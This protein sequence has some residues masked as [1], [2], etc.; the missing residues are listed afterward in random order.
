MKK[1]LI[2]NALP[3]VLLFITSYTFGQNSGGDSSNTKLMRH[4]FATRGSHKNEL[5]LGDYVIGG[6]FASEADAKDLT[7]ELK[8]QGFSTT[9]YGYLSSKKFWYIYLNVS[10]DIEI[11]KAERDKYQKLKM[12]NDVW[13]LTVHK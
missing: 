4:E 11:A 3:L 8:K 12:F 1:S 5:N 7:D 9:G 2:R 10:D 13:L 6:A